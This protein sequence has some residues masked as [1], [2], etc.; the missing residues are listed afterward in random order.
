[1]TGKT[2]DK[3]MIHRMG[4]YSNQ[5]GIAMRYLREDD[6]WN[7]HLGNT[8]RFVLSVVK[9]L[10][11]SLVTVLGSGWLLDI[12]L[13][14][15]IRLGCRVRLID[16]VHPPGIVKSLSDEPAVEIVVDDITGGLTEMTWHIA[17]ARRKPEI[18]EIMEALGTLE[19]STPDDP[20]L[21]LSVNL[22]SQLSTL[23]FDF[24]E[25]R[26]ILKPDSAIEFS[27]IIQQKHLEFL[28][29]HDSVLVTDVAELQTDRNGILHRRELIH[30]K[31][32]SG[33]M[34]REWTWQF[35]SGGSY[36]QGHTTNMQ[37]VA[38]HI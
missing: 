23:P 32:P 31:L 29:K 27:R 14:E 35:D 30:S 13:L 18:C 37:V 19:Y 6:N 28:R 33:S 22:L 4:Y 3:N 36:K 11:P 7:E 2:L 34:R 15:I 10:K 1:M 16:L 20:G 12:P 24:L 9:K 5:E 38:I 25:K 17:A 8:R 21:L 26:R